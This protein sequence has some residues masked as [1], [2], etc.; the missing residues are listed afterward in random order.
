M[1]RKLRKKGVKEATGGLT[2]SINYEKKKGQRVQ[3]LATHEDCLMDVRGLGNCSKWPIVKEV[4]RTFNTDILL[5]QESKLNSIQDSIIKEVWGRG[6]IEWRSCNA[7]GLPGG[8]LIIWNSR[9]FYC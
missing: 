1:W 2:C 9:L 7:V 4:I 5:I 8:V 6:S 3:P